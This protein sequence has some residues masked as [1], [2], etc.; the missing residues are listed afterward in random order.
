MVGILMDRVREGGCMCGSVRFTARGPARTLVCYCGFCQKVTGSAFL[1]E[2]VFPKARVEFAGGA[3]AVYAYRS[4]AH[5]RRLFVQFCASCGS[6]FGLTTERFPENQCLF[7]GAFDDPSP[8]TPGAQ[9]FTDDAPKWLDFQ[10][11][12]D[13]YREHVFKVDGGMNEP[14]RKAAPRNVM[15]DAFAMTRPAAGND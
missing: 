13:C 8:F 1:V 5:G 14:W 12:S 2:A 11:G 10:S 15:T 4:P 3:V 6:S 7:A 9:I